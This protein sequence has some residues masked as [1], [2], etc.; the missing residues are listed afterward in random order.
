MNQGGHFKLLGL[1]GSKS[2][3]DVQ[4]DHYEAGDDGDGQSLDDMRE[5]GQGGAEAGQDVMG[6]VGGVEEGG[7]SILHHPERLFRSG[8]SEDQ[9][10]TDGHQGRDAQHNR[11]F[12]QIGGRRNRGQQRVDQVAFGGFIVR[13]IGH[14][15][16]HQV[17]RVLITLY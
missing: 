15:H 4:G 1:S 6:I 2:E 5:R 7:H 9:V 12:D 16:L 3:Q 11:G 13:Q 17:C 14:L 10:H 8:W